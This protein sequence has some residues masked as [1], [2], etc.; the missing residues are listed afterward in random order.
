MAQQAFQAVFG[1]KDYTVKIAMFN[2]EG[3]VIVLKKNAV[4]MLEIDDN[5]FNPFHSGTILLTND[6]N[7]LEN[8]KTPYVFLGN[9]SD[10]LYL[11]I[12][13]NNS[14]ARF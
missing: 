11:D 1:D 8:G 7:I 6:Y 12:Q 3:D 14:S 9:G 13:P 4:R 10:M 2:S 5:I